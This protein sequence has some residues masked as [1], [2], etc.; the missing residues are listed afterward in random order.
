[1][2]KSLLVGVSASVL[3]ALAAPETIP[4]VT[5][6]S[7]DV[8][9]AIAEGVASW[10]GIPYATPPL[11]E[12]RWKPPQKPNDWATVRPAIAVGPACPQPER[13]DGIGAGA[14]ATQSEDCL[15]LNVFAPVGA[16]N[17]P[18]MVWIHGGAFRVGYGG[19][20]LYDGAELAKQGVVLVTMNYRLGLLGF[21]A[22]P[23]LTAAATP[24]EAL[25]NY[26]LMDQLLA[27]QW[28][29][30][31][32]AA[33]GGDPRNVTAFGESAGGSSMLYLLANPRSKGLFSKAIV[34]SGGGL[35]QPVGLKENEQ[36]GVAFAARIGLDGG[37]TPAALRA[38]RDR[39]WVT[40]QGGLQGLGF[41]P[42]MDGRFV[43]EAPWQ[44][45]KDHRAVDVPLLIGANSN[46]SSVLTTLG[47]NAAALAGVTGPRMAELRKLYGDVTSDAEFSRQAMGDLAF[48]APARW[49]AG[50]ASS[51][52]PSYLYYFSYVA[53][54]RRSVTPGANHGAE[55]PYVFKSW[56]NMPVLAR[57][58]TA[59]D[60]AMSNMLSACWVAFARTGRPACAGAPEW[61]AYM[62]DS[63]Q[64]TEFGTDVRVGKPSRAKA[65]DLLVSQ[66]LST[67]R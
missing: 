61:P 67:L 9:G 46:E 15:T 24:A 45:F 23:A 2:L 59:Q 47:V 30:D 57:V 22:H 44:A 65:F 55:I 42:F 11:G 10:K 1:M 58:M 29:Q 39:D 56:V 51:G 28:V 31:N 37:A 35:Q 4:V 7:G 18:V 25:G 41:G 36:R 5:T 43:T 62:P 12:L 32:I 27:L 63:D 14:P 33:F 49:I 60:K 40:A 8:S 54:A 53:A 64:Q 34:E 17:L 16:K 3:I 66:V 52:A 20:P 21:F 19:A 50:M 6:K 38:R 13:G 26:G 48:V